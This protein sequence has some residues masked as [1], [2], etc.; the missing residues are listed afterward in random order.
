MARP[1]LEIDPAQVE[2][3]AAIGCSMAEIGAVLSCSP[4]T[5]QRRFAAVIEKGRE[6]GKASLK[7]KQYEVAMSGN[8]SMLIWLGKIKLGQVDTSRQFIDQNSVNIN[9]NV[10]AEAESSELKEIMADLKTL[11][12]TKSN[13]R[14]G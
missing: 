12:D 8:V 3:L 5:L 10:N 14:K 9:A 11:I 13:E 7:R 2:K 1:K 6:H 4:D